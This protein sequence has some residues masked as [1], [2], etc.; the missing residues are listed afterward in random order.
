MTA[1]YQSLTVAEC[2]D[3]LLVLPDRVKVLLHIR[4][5]GDT[6]GSGAALC[7]LLRLL[8][9][10]AELYSPDKIPQRLEFLTEGITLSDTPEGCAAVSIDVASPSQLGNSYGR[11]DI[12][13]TIDHH[14]RNTPYAPNLTLGDKSSAGEVL[15]TVVKELISRGLV[16]MTEALAMRLYAAISSDTGR[17]AYSNCSPDT[18]RAAAQLMEYGFDSS[19]VN[20]LLF[21]SKTKNQI[22]AEGL[23][24]SLMKTSPDGR[25]TYAAVSLSDM[26]AAGIAFPDLETG[27]DVVRSLM[28][29]EVSFIIKEL[30]DGGMK[31]SL[32]ST[33]KDVS[34]IA[35]KHGGGGHIRAAACT[36]T[37]IS[38]KEATEV[39]LC[40]CEKLFG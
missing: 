9:K 10:E 26:E 34:A 3:R 8:G 11:A 4:P 27:I 2:A 31:V 38:I 14:E 17:F 36:L 23:V 40:E 29:C 19:R 39:L 25:I 20:R 18:H 37:G 30:C 28:G 13:L 21:D 24:A 15:Y 35:V 33:G 16:T 6:V 12:H 5:D 1:E 32:R 7:E 22:K